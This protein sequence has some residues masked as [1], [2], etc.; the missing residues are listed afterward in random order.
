MKEFVF[1]YQLSTINYQLLSFV[2][3]QHPKLSVGEFAQNIA[4]QFE[5]KII[6]G[7]DG[8]SERKIISPR[9]QKLGLALAGF[10]RYIHSGRVQIVGQSEISYLWQMDREKRLEAIRNLSPDQICCILITTSLEPPPELVAVCDEVNLPLLTT[11]SVSSVAIEKVSRFLQNQLAPQIY[12]HGVL[13]EIYGHG[14]FITG[15]SGIGKSEC[16]LDLISRGHRL[17]SDDVAIIKKIEDRLEGSS[18]ELTREHLEIRGLGI[19]NVRY[20][21]GVS[22]ISDTITIDLCI[23]L[24]KWDELTEIERLG[25]EH[26]VEDIFGVEIVKFVLPVSPGRNLSTLVETAVRIHLLKKSGY[27]AAAD[28]T[29][30][31]SRILGN[32]S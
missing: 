8:A 29:E 21:F 4:G 11:P 17:V 3:S 24:K 18:P 16:A 12:R 20:L 32:D 23:E 6:A 31:H 10:A 2:R 28:L 22:A 5:L 15:E 9:I 26:R 19:I 30:K 25:V 7:A 27:D 13:L 14:I 1:R